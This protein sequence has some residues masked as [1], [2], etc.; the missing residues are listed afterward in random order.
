ME[1]PQE[2]QRL[3]DY[4]S[5]GTSKDSPDI[6]FVFGRDDFAIA[7]KA[8]EL[9]RSYRK[10]LILLGG[11]GR[12]TGT[13][14]GSEAEAF[15]DH[16]LL[17]GVPEQDMVLETKSSNTG[18]N[19]IEG[20]AIL[21]GLGIYSRVGIVTHAPHVRRT[22]AAARLHAPQIDW[23]LFPDSCTID[24]QPLAE[25]VKELVGEVD[26]LETYPALGYIASDPIP[27]DILEIRNLLRQRLQ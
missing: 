11:R 27:L 12:L 8:A 5:I 14:T 9:Y 3:W 2:I 1:H 25:T 18:E 10:K 16:L 24:T 4:L 19:I 23:L 22:L 26:R 15:R 13:I 7:D 21:Q 17:K 6:F 20:L